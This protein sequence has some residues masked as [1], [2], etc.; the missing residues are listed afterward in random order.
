MLYE[1]HI[2]DNSLNFKAP[3][4][5]TPA[6]NN[7]GQWLTFSK[8]LSDYGTCKFRVGTK[9]P[10]FETEGDILRP[11]KNYVRIK[12]AGVTVWTGVIAKNTSRNSDYIEVEAYSYM[13][14]LSK[15]LLRHDA[16][17][18]QGGENY[19]SLKSGTMAA[20]I[21]TL[22]SEAKLDMGGALASLTNGTI[23]N[24]TFPADYKDSAGTTLSGTWT[25]SP[26]FT[27]KF[28]YRPIL[29]VLQVLGAYAN[30]DFEVDENM[31]FSFQQ[32]LGNR[33]PEIKFFY[34]T[35]GNIANYDAPLDGDTM[36]NYI[37]G[38]AADNQFNILHADVTDSASIATYGKI[39]GVAAYADVKNTNLLK[40]RIREELNLVAVPDQEVHIVLND[41]AYP[42]GVYDI[43][44]TVTVQISDHLIDIDEQRRIVG[45]EVAVLT[46]GEEKI[47]LITNKPKE[48]Q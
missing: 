5:V 8:K 36:A 27:V 12:R 17:D 30:F 7:K 9:D 20:N 18:G 2:L 45:I 25:F 42:M 10:L 29:Y 4:R 3:I 40:S 41:K 37:I 44:D 48:S 11:F 33:K 16:A 14:L 26:T 23:D 28:D 39:A 6:L 22:L 32:F 47:T 38:V 13:Y 1:I 19:R 21:T 15:V 24:P 43:G 46:T 34:G 35:T 31:I